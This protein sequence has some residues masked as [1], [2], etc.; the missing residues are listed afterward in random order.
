MDVGKK[1]RMNS[2]FRKD[3][4]NCVCVAVDHG[5][6]AGPM[7]GL[8][9]PGPLIRSCIKGR[10]D[11]ILTTRGFARAAI[12]EWDRSI[13]LVLRLTGG[14]TVLGGVFEEEMISSP[15]T[16]LEYG[17]DGAAVTVKFGH[18]REGEV[19]KN[20]SLVADECNRWGL[21]VMIES[22]AKKK[23][24]PS[25]DPEGIKLAARAAMEIGADMVK[26]YYTGDVETFGK[27][28]EGCQI[29]VVILGGEKNNSLEEVFNDVYYSMQA[30]ARGIAIGRNIW[31]YKNTTAMV[32]AMA[33]LVHEKWTVKQ[34]MKHIT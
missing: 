20:A 7:E 1:L 33:G 32:E 16:A 22:M 3:T 14:F 29:P 6:I 23:D 9:A 28:I 19:I 31:Q 17:A 4:G 12:D 27:V 34:A 21:P 5:G 8:N 24:M 15:R 13:A 26:T 18:P 10:A 2:L 30:G 25:A 11:C